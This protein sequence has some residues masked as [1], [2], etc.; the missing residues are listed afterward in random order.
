MQA[1][2]SIGELLGGEDAVFVCVDSAEVL[3]VAEG[4]GLARYG[5]A[6]KATAGARLTE[7]LPEGSEGLEQWRR[8]LAGERLHA[9]VTHGETHWLQLF[10]PRRAA[11]GA[12]AGATMLALD[13]TRE[14]LAARRGRLLSDLVNN[15]QTNVFAIGSD[16]ICMISEGGLLRTLGYAPGQLEGVDVYQ[17]FAGIPELSAALQRALHGEVAECEYTYGP[18][19]IKQTCLPRFD[20]LG[21]VIATY[22]VASEIAEQ[23]RTEAL[24][25]EQVQIIQDQKEAILRLSTPIIEVADDVLAIPVIGAVDGDRAAILMHGLLVA[26]SHKRARYAILDLTGVE[27]IDTDTAAHLVRVV[28][29]VRLLGAQAIITGIRPAIAQTL[30]SLGIELGGLLTLGS[31]RDALRHCATRR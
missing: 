3:T 15:V 5:L 17:A 31:L 13:V 8:C 28:H 1:L 22:C 29:S 23:R 4:R 20:A 9:E 19:V 30:T 25:R 2:D 10:A 6:G 11:D 26:I 24:L 27:N 16:G 21:K 14:L 18:F 12:A 7:L